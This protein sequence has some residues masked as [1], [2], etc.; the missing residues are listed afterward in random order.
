MNRPRRF[1]GGLLLLGALLLLLTA[2]GAVTLWTYDHPL[3][4]RLALAQGAVYAV[5]AWLLVGR[6]VE[7][8]LD[9]RALVAILVLAAAMRALLI[10]APPVSTDIYRYVWDGRVQAAGVNPYLHVPADPALAG[11]RDEPIYPRINRG[12]YAPTIY[13]PTAQMVFYAVTRLS[14]TVWAMK[15]ATVAFEAAIV[16]ALLQLLAARGLP[17]SRVLLYA[18]HPLP[19]WE[20]AGSGHVDA[21][22]IAFLLLAFVAADRGRPTL[23]GIALGAGALVKYFPVVAGPALYRRWDWRLPVAFAATVVVLYLP[24]LGAGRKVFGFLGEYVAEQGFERGWGIYLWSLAGS[25][26]ALPD[27][28]FAIYFPAAA[29]ILAALA[30][31][32]VLRRRSSGADLAGAMTLAVAFMVLFSPHHAW[33]FAWLV[34]FLCIHP[35]AAVI[36]LTCAATTIYMTGWPPNLG[37]GTVLYGPFSVLL[38]AELLLRRNRI[39]KEGCHDHAVA[40]PRNVAA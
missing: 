20:F 4:F 37:G 32:V 30:L 33:Y 19:L 22:A 27:Q 9:H 28:A 15:A 24:Y 25:L 12:D 5:A 34:P 39:A 31:F 14:E 23:A 7:R 1:G 40:A 10:P 17:A 36:Y 3:L 6:G 18:W 16:W 8:A 35:L 21:A 26:V 38:A 29:A 13:P 2:A 11:L